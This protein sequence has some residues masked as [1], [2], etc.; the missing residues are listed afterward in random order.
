MK[1]RS[2]RSPTKTGAAGTHHHRDPGVLEL[3][4][5]LPFHVQ[6]VRIHDLRA[7]ALGGE[8]A[9]DHRG[10]VG[11]PE[12]DP[13]VLAHSEL[14]EGGR[15][16]V[17]LVFQEHDVAARGKSTHRKFIRMGTDDVERAYTD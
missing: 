3:V 8:E 9:D 5:E 14:R 13:A 1:A 11:H 15:E 6:R 10:E 7:Q 16:T 2:V 12:R 4:H 17:D